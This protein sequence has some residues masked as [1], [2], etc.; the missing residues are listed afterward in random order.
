MLG[1]L[2][3]KPF[4]QALLKAFR[5]PKAAAGK[6]RA[7]HP[8]ADIAQEDAAGEYKEP[9]RKADYGT[10]NLLRQTR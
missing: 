1:A 7:L 4:M 3:W 6:P 10:S 2:S 8:P 5:H 9:E